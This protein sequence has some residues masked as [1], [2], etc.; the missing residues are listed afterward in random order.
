MTSIVAQ[1]SC[2]L[3]G[4]REPTRGPFAKHGVAIPLQELV[5]AIPI[6]R[7]IH[8][9][10]E[11]ILHQ[12]PRPRAMRHTASERVY[13]VSPINRAMDFPDDTSSFPKLLAR[14]DWVGAKEQGSSSSARMKSTARLQRPQPRQRRRRVGFPI[15][16]PPGGTHSRCI[17]KKVAISARK[18]PEP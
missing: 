7:G 2:A 18:P 16:Q 8:R 12:P 10:H 4:S 1:K 15:P 3:R 6:G 9:S 11:R 17:T 14:S 5:Q 13:T